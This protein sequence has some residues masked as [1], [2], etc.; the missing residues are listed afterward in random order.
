MSASAFAAAFRRGCLDFVPVLSGVIPFA[1]I[2]GVAAVQAGLTP[3]E[4]AAMSL[5][6]YAG[7]AQLVAC[8]MIATGS[9][10]ALIVATSLVV[11]L[12]FA[13]YS[14]SI[15]PHLTRL[16]GPLKLLGA[17]AL[18]DQTYAL[19]IARLERGEFGSAGAAY[20]LGAAA[21]MWGAW[22]IGNLSGALLG[23]GLPAAWSL[24]FSI[25]L[26]F[27]ALAVPTL[28][29]RPALLAALVAG[30]T[31]VALAALPYRLGLIV[32]ALAGIAAGT[33]ARRTLPLSRAE[34]QP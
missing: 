21:L 22:Q 8:S 34:Q 30:A 12:R 13:M 2:A 27:I 11:N 15:A 29:S 19:A 25:A 6:A 1:L 31:A 4:A 9:P 7:S 3:L 26:T 20:Y 17:Y 33:L 18:T 10:A 16:P 28:R 5:I 14:A 24:D 23:S 32:A